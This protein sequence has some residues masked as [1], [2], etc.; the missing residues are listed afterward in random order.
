MLRPTMSF[1]FRLWLV[2]DQGWLGIPGLKPFC[3]S[4]TSRSGDIMIVSGSRHLC[5][6]STER[7]AKFGRRDGRCDFSA[8]D[9]HSWRWKNSELVSLPYFLANKMLFNAAILVSF[10]VNIFLCPFMPCKLRNG[11]CILI[12]KFN[13]IERPWQSFLPELM[14]MVPARLGSGIKTQWN[15]MIRSLCYTFNCVFSWQSS[16][17]RA[18]QCSAVP[19]CEISQPMLLPLDHTLQDIP[20]PR[21]LRRWRWMS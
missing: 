2:R 17:P 5:W 12:R 4:S 13:T 11:H 15:T 18:S 20:R 1:D 14:L 8:L 9:D 19:P 6:C 16:F 10:C 21:N 3:T 7:H